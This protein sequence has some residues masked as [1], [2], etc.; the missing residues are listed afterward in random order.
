MTY[1]QGLV[2]Y[3]GT[4]TLIQAMQ[5]VLDRMKDALSKQWGA[6]IWS[7]MVTDMC[8]LSEAAAKSVLEVGGNDG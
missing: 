8:R 3:A 2:V 5:V 7:S 1:K 4:D 6:D